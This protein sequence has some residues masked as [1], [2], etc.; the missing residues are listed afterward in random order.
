MATTIGWIDSAYHVCMPCSLWPKDVPTGAYEGAAASLV[1]PIYTGLQQLH[2]CY[3]YYYY[4]YS[5]TCSMYVCIRVHMYVC[6][7]VCT[8]R[9]DTSQDMPGHMYA[10]AGEPE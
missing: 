8:C 4:Y 9:I 3:Y 1:P 2:R 5:R 10:A 7:N 6:M